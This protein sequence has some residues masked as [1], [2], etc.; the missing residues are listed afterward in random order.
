MPYN[1]SGVGSRESGAGAVSIDGVAARDVVV[2][3]DA[4]AAA[5]VLADAA[6]L[7]RAVAPVGGGT[8]LNMG[9]SPERVDVI[10]STAR[11]GGIIDYEPTDLVLSAGAGARFGDVQA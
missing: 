9:N 3:D 7:G 5:D 6:G 8:A 1:E 2:P 4:Q 11:L 10:L